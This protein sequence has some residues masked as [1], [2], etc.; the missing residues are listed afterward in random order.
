MELPY[1]HRFV[2]VVVENGWASLE[3]EMEWSYQKEGAERAAR[4]VRGLDGIANELRVQRYTEPAEIKG[5]LEE[6]FRRRA[7]AG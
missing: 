3:G 4:R 5:R 6:A 2:K 1:S 7:R